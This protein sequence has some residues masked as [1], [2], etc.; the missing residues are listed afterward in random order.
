MTGTCTAE[1]DRG[2]LRYTTLRLADIYTADP[3]ALNQGYR[4]RA[5]LFAVSRTSYQLHRATRCPSCQQQLL[6]GEFRLQYHRTTLLALPDQQRW[7]RRL[8]LFQHCEQ[9]GYHHHIRFSNDPLQ[10]QHG[11][12]RVPTIRR[13]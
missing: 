10:P 4:S 7:H 8:D 12:S 5:E 13:C 11:H 1:S 9:C 3:Q 2:L 6:G